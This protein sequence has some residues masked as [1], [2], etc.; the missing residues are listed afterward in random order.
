MSIDKSF[1]NLENTKTSTGK[2]PL[3]FGEALGVYDAFNNPYPELSTLDE[4]QR[5]L[6]WHSSE[7]SL[8][9]S[10]ADMKSADPK[11][12]ELMVRNLSFQMA[13]D[14][15][16]SGSIQ[17]LFFPVLTNHQA[18][19]LISYHGDSETV[20]E[21]SYALIVAQC[22]KD[23]NDMYKRISEDMNILKRLKPIGNAFK[24]YKQI[25]LDNPNNPLPVKRRSVIKL[26]TSFVALEGIMFC[27]SFMA[28]FALADSTGMFNGIA[29]RVGLIHNDEWG[30]HLENMMA[31]LNIIIKKEKWAEWKEMQLEVKEILDAAV[32]SEE[33]WADSLFEGCGSV[34]GFNSEVLKDYGYF[35]SG[36]I[37]KR[38]GI[39]F[40]FPK[41][42]SSPKWLENYINPNLVQ[43]APQEVQLGNY[44]TGAVSNDVEDDSTFE[45]DL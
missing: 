43:S 1:L 40:D 34:V 22:F 18:K 42:N 7:F 14:S 36:K 19:K 9:Q 37:Y 2:N 29:K 15:L 28:T 31:F 12:V 38:L 39:Q 35:L 17:E 41:V 6:F 45:F 20:H 23:P 5:S 16:A 21:E 8:A 44:L 30:C 33:S 3:F 4:K 25:V 24:E 10:A 32:R 27:N 13:A 11:I 26:V